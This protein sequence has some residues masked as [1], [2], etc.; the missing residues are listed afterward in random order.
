MAMHGSE[1]TPPLLSLPQTFKFEEIQ[2]LHFEVYDV[3]TSYTSADSAKIDPKKQV[4]I[5]AM[6]AR[7]SK[8]KEQAFVTH[9]P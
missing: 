8:Q 9:L 6:A 4:Y 7:A 3:D 2:T 5:L 1:Y